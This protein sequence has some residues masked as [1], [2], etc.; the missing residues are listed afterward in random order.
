M[1]DLI[2]IFL[3]F[4]S[5]GLSPGRLLALSSEGI[6][7]SRD[8]GLS[9][10]PLHIFHVHLLNL[11]NWSFSRYTHLLYC[12]VCTFFVC[13]S[14]REWLFVQT[15]HGV[16]PPLPG[17]TPTVFFT[18]VHYLKHASSFRFPMLCYLS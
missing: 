14:S 15:K 17:E 13:G 16:I 12:T 3:L 5:D 8:A 1:A 6:P 4:L 9:Y 2:T 7:P 11:S 10:P 18:A